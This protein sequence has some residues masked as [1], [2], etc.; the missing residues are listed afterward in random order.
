MLEIQLYLHIAQFYRFDYS[1]ILTGLKIKAEDVEVCLNQPKNRS[2]YLHDIG[3][4]GKVA[5]RKLLLKPVNIQQKKQK[6]TVLSDHF[7]FV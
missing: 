2:T 7:S 5:C 1:Q 3:H 6:T 4:F